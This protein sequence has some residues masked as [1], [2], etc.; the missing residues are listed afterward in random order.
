M[1]SRKGDISIMQPIN[2][3]AISRHM[4]SYQPVE[5]FLIDHYTFKLYALYEKGFSMDH[6]YNLIV[7]LNEEPVVALGYELGNGTIHFLRATLADRHVNFGEAPK[8]MDL[9][10]FRMWALQEV[11]NFLEDVDPQMLQS[12]SNE[13]AVDVEAISA[14]KG[15]KQFT[16][17]PFELQMRKRIKSIV[18]NLRDFHDVI[19]YRYVK[20]FEQSLQGNEVQLVSLENAQLVLASET[21]A[22]ELVAVIFDKQHHNIESILKWLL[23]KEVV[24]A[25]ASE[26]EPLIAGKKVLATVEVEGYIAACLQ[27]RL[28][29]KLN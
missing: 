12:K 17:T 25:R 15:E 11:C 18:R 5:Q 8:G 16:A 22:P 2:H 3:Q 4:N 13:P 21:D 26:I 19:E 24:F 1:K 28:G 9:L 29:N 27:A 14:Y 23:E 20:N 7:F 6:K 10:S